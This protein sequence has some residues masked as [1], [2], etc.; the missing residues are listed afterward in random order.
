MRNMLHSHLRIDIF[1]R[2]YGIIVYSKTNGTTNLEH[3]RFL[4]DLPYLDRIA[5]ELFSHREISLFLILLSDMSPDSTGG[6][7]LTYRTASNYHHL[8]FHFYMHYDHFFHSLLYCPRVHAFDFS[9]Q[10]FATCS[11]KHTIRD[12]RRAEADL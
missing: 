4:Q 9:A 10:L 12:P 3:P 5:V 2:S 8:P 6:F 11:R 7:L 1:N